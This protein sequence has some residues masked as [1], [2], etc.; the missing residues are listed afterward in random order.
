VL[1]IIESDVSAFRNRRAARNSKRDVL[2]VLERRRELGVDQVRVQRLVWDVRESRDGQLLVVRSV[3]HDV[4]NAGLRETSGRAGVGSEAEP[5]ALKVEGLNAGAGDGLGEGV[6]RQ[7][8]ELQEVKGTGG[9]CVLGLR[10]RDYAGKALDRSLET[11]VRRDWEMC[12][13]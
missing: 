2:Q 3:R 13:G 7:L 6:K 10:V 1:D 8:A 9:A 11:I 4:E 12:S 5:E